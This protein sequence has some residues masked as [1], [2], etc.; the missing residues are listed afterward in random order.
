M[1]FPF[2]LKS[3]VLGLATRPGIEQIKQG[4]AA[5]TEVEP[6]GNFLVLNTD[7][8]KWGD[9]LLYMQ[10]TVGTV[11][12]LHGRRPNGASLL[13]MQT[14]V[15][16]RTDYQCLFRVEYHDGVA[17]RHY[18][19]WVTNSAILVGLFGSY[20]ARDDAY[21]DMVIWRDMSHLIRSLKRQMPPA[22]LAASFWPDGEYERYV[23]KRERM[24][25]ELTKAWKESNDLD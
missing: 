12:L 14:T 22:E 4:L 20:L 5:L 13:Y 18:F 25:K 7:A 24:D 1:N 23:Q 21:L 6:A 17:G 9:G 11:A 10:T 3:S 19:T 2:T 15:G 16:T 8:L